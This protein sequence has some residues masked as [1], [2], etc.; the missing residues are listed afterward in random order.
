MKLMAVMGTIAVVPVLVIFPTVETG[1]FADIRGWM[2]ISRIIHTIRVIF[3]IVLSFV[4][5]GTI[6][7][8]E[9]NR[10]RRTKI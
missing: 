2:V 1:A 7:N 4:L 8:P 3:N 9:I 6:I 5:F 10:F